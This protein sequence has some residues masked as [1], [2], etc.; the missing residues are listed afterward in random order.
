[1]EKT[2]GMELMVFNNGQFGDVRATTIDGE[3]WFVAKDVA[4][5][6]GYSNPR[7]ALSKH[8]DNE[9]RNTVAIRDG[10]RG[11]PQVTVIN[12]SGMY[13]LIL[14]SKLPKAKEFKH[15][16]TRD[17][18]PSIR[19]RGEYVTEEKKAQAYV[20]PDMSEE[21]RKAMDV[22]VRMMK[23]NE[24]LKKTVSDLTG[25]IKQIESSKALTGCRR[26]I[27]AAMQRYASHRMIGG[28]NKANAAG[29][30]WNMFYGAMDRR[31]GIDINSRWERAKAQPGGKNAKKMDQ[32]TDTEAELGA[33]V[34][35]TMC[36]ME[37]V[38]VNDLARACMDCTAEE[39]M[40]MAS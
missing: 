22:F 28:M 14:G 23:E 33:G 32:L 35:A 17:V 36:Y 25:R 9:D 30:G 13:A 15:W 6:L 21:L 38:D 26:F 24:D 8:V 11:N 4:T 16:V 37:N 5:V 27:W 7:D 20:S 10:N 3:P 39:A 18:L 1:M 31:Y 34:A 12:E 19:K 29:E 2:N 40:R